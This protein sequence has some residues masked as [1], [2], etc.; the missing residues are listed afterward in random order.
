MIDGEKHN[1]NAGNLAHFSDV[2]ISDNVADGLIATDIDDVDLT[3]FSNDSVD[4]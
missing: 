1:I 4:V 3:G 2:A